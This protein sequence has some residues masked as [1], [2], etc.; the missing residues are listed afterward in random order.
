M[1]IELKFNT[2]NLTPLEVRLQLNK[3]LR[4]MLNLRGFSLLELK[5]FVADY[6]DVSI[7]EIAGRNQN[8]NSVDARQLFCY[9]AYKYLHKSLSQIGLSV[10]RE[11]ATVSY[12]IKKVEEKMEGNVA[13]RQK[14][15]CI[16]IHFK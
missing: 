14:V 2:E 11:H 15:N 13:F 3:A 16:E 8:E 4:S 12:S 5:E 1:I 10:D 9:L 6:M 7:E